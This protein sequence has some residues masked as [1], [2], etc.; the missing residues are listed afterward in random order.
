MPLAGTAAR[1]GAEAHPPRTELDLAWRQFGTAGSP[2]EYC[3][4]WLA[5]QCHAVGGVHHAVVVLQKPGGESFAPLAFWPEER[6]ARSGLSEITERALREGRGIVQPV[7]ARDGLPAS[8]L[9]DQPDYQIAYPIRLDGRLRGV[10]GLEIGWREAAQLQ[11]AMRQL[12]WG[13]GW[14]EVLLR[15]HADPVE[16]A[17]QRI[18]LILQLTA[19]FLER[20]EFREAATD[21]VTETATR[22]GC[23]RVVLGLAQ[24]GGVRIEAVSHSAQFDRH[25]N[26]LAATVAAMTEALD[27]RESIAY[28]QDREARPVVT[29][30]HAELAQLSGADG[31]ATVLLMHQGRAVGALT[32]ERAGGHRFDAPAMELLEGLA[33]ML[34][35][36]IE[37]RLAQGRSL[38]AQAAERAQGFWE[39]LVGP[40]HAGLKLGAGA[41]AAA[42]LFLG[43]ASGEYRVAADARIEGKVQRTLTAPFQGYVR[44]SARRAGDTVRKGEVLARLDDRDLRLEQSRLQ[45]QRDQLGRQYREAMAKRDR[46]QARIVSAQLEQSQAQLALIDEH[47]QRTEIAAPFD[48]VL[49]SGDLT[50]MLGAPLERGQALFEIAPLDAY[51]VVL[52]VDEHR[53]AE[54]REGMRG[55]L[56][57]SSNPGQHFAILLQKIT[58]VSTARDG[59]NYFRV[60][61]TLESGPDPRMRPGM[62]GVAKVSVDDRRLAWIWTRELA[63][64]LRLKAWAWTP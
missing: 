7:Q 4:N 3:R 32:L 36:M 5:L 54:V 35:P 13:S 15:R 17:R 25:A 2:E 29:L 30:A 56:V 51:R 18:K 16:A 33:A 63:N 53:V 50:Q 31:I 38:T 47:L 42:A 41:L 10:V 6:P 39:R 9:P 52:Q 21:L 44:E 40:R 46:A 11:A 58:P 14:L 45:A 61:A 49:V 23:D 8:Q 37:L 22:L 64:W 27:Q 28:P 55:E 20:A 57:L 43:F 24:V 12:Q 48:G 34:G 62:E 26:L 59:R 1:D 19:I 60:E